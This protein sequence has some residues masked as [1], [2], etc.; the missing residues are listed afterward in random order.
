[1]GKKLKGWDWTEL[2]SLWPESTK[3]KWTKPTPSNLLIDEIEQIKWLEDKIIG[4]R[5]GIINQKKDRNRIKMCRKFVSLL[6]KND[7]SFS[8]PIFKGLSKIKDDMTFL[9]Y[10]SVLLPYLWT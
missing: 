5:E 9:D 7:T 1:M 2:F 6:V 10:L 3:V 4:L 8:K